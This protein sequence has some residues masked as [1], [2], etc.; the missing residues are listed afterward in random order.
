VSNNALIVGAGTGLSAALARAFAGA[1]MKV[2]LAARDIAKLAALCREIGAE[3]H[4]CDAADPESVR[5]LFSKLDAHT[6]APELVVYNAGLRIRGAIVELDAADIDAAWRVGA[7]GGFLVGQE[8]ARRMLELG[9]G[10]IL[11]TGATASVKGFALS[12]GFAMAK[13][14]LRGLAQS[15]AREL[16][17]K[18]IHVAH[19]IIDG[20]IRR[21]EESE[22]ATPRVDYS[23]LDAAAIAESYL[24]LHRQKP[25]SWSHE[26]DLRPRLE[27][28]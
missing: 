20:A 4:V 2:V 25:T 14:A 1:G 6:R 10:T 21:S 3:A 8:A 23:K 13:F 22:D 27:R 11:F 24:A 5:R 7:F 18:G 12:A 17:P 15:M 26:I 28:F 19:V 9:R 16:Q